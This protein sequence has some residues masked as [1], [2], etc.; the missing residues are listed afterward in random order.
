MSSSVYSMGMPVYQT[1][2][3]ALGCELFI[4]EGRSKE[5][6]MKKLKYILKKTS[7]SKSIAVHDIG[8]RP[9]KPVPIA[10]YFVECHLLSNSL[11]SKVNAYWWTCYKGEVQNND[12]D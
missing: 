7:A 3:Y 6:V 9:G 4:L 11:A 12:T 10:R 8:Y 1:P 5:Q 2:T